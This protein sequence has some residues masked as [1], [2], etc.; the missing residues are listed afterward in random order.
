MLSDQSKRQQYDQFGQ[1]FD[2]QGSSG[3]GGQGGFDFSQKGG[4]G[5]SWNF[6]YGGSGFED[7]FS[8]IFGGGGTQTQG[9]KAGRDIQVDVE[10]SFE[11]MVRGSTRNIKIYKRIVCSEC[12]GSGA[13]PKAEV[14]TCPTCQGSGRV[15][16]TSQS[17]FGMFSQVVQCSECQG[18]GKVFSQKCH[19]CGGDGR[20]KE[21]VTVKANIP[22]GISDGQTVSFP[23]Y[24]EAGERG[25]PSGDLYA[26]VHIRP[27][28]KFIRQG[29]DISSQEK[30][31]FAMA[32]LGGK[33]EVDTIDG[34]LILKIPSGTQP[35]EIF[36][37]KGKGATELQGRS[38]GNHLV[39][40]KVTV[41]KSLSREQ[42]KII[43]DLSRLE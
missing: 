30:I 12:Q 11:E 24:G 15:Q 16:K 23:G 18:E 38:R 4:S 36:R 32:A 21:E 26:T 25:A 6:E 8:D 20:I 22:A 43:E 29:K 28:E 3:Q 42:K 31:T 19:R 34:P 9:K 39:K 37:I 7:I 14:K 2:G 5:G 1:T 27:H 10:I 40:I 13:H 33:I 17:F 35:G 41:P